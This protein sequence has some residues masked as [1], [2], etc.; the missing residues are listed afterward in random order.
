MFDTGE[1]WR[2]ISIPGLLAERDP[3]G[4][5]AQRFCQREPSGPPSCEPTDGMEEFRQLVADSSS[6][7]SSTDLDIAGNSL[8]EY[9]APEPDAECQAEET[10]DCG[11]DP[12]SAIYYRVTLSNQRYYIDYWWFFRF[13]HF[14][15]FSATC[16]VPSKLCDEHEGDWEGVTLVTPPNDDQS[17]D[18]AVYAAHK[19][20]FRYPADQLRLQDG[21]RPEVFVAYGSHASYPQPCPSFCSQPIAIAGLVDTPETNTDGQSPWE[22]NDDSCP[23]NAPGSCLLA[24]PAP[25]TDPQAWTAW[26]GLWGATCGERCGHPSNPQ[27][28]ASP[29]QQSRF[30]APWCSTVNGVL[31]CD[32]VAQGCSDWLGPLVAALACDPQ[33]LGSGLTTPKSLPT[34]DL[35]LTVARPGPTSRDTSSATTRGIVQDL[36]PP[37]K[38][39]SQLTVS[40]AG[41]GTQLLVRARKSEQLLEARFDPFSTEHQGETFLVRI[42]ARHGRPLAR[43]L[44]PGGAV[45]EPVEQRRLQLSDAG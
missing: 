9:R 38:P 10:L 7:G 8:S 31:T 21:L 18:Y 33:A 20:L 44:R 41:R 6:L 26:P 3:S 29:G 30:Q 15:G 42:S 4:S 5:P 25:E 1:K 37:L 43:G 23:A 35:R 13:N 12:S 34:G 36:G 14:Q 24:L 17:L 2:P 40:G 22:R 27:S 39:G 11:N 19:G 32:G 28:P 16:A 45:V